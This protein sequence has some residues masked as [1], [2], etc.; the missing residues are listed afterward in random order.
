METDGHSMDNC[1]FREKIENNSDRSK[2]NKRKI[3]QIMKGDW[4][5][6][7]QLFEMIQELQNH[8]STFNKNFEKYN[9]LIEEREK[10]RELLNELN[11]KVNKIETRDESVKKTNDS[12]KDWISWGISF[13]LF[14]LYLAEIGVIK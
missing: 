4:Y 10:D 8:I 13:I 6:N 12:W 2:D 7:Q 3:E 14:I 5:S 11:D 9:G 1:P